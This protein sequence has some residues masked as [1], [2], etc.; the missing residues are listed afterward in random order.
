MLSP[1]GFR[2]TSASRC[3][4]FMTTDYRLHRNSSFDSIVAY[5]NHRAAESRLPFNVGASRLLHWLG[6]TGDVFGTMFLV[7]TRGENISVEIVTYVLYCCIMGTNNGILRRGRPQPKIPYQ[8]SQARGGDDRAV[9][10]AFDAERQKG[11]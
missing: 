1:L 7:N 3:K 6:F 5:V 2:V 4:F 8:W 10:I 11:K 9:R